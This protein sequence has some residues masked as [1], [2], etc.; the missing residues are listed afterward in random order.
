MPALSALALMLAPVP[1]DTR[2]VSREPVWAGF[3]FARAAELR[4]VIDGEPTIAIFAPLVEE[5]ETLLYSAH[6]QTV[7]LVTGHVF[8]DELRPLKDSGLA[9]PRRARVRAPGIDHVALGE[10]D[11]WPRGVV[12]VVSG[13]DGTTSHLLTGER[14]DA[15]FGHACANIGDIDRD[16]LDD[17]VVGAPGTDWCPN[18]SDPEGAVYVFSGRTLAPL[19]RRA[20]DGPGS[21]FGFALAALDDVDRDGVRDLAVSA[22]FR[23]RVHVLSGRDGTLVRTITSEAGRFGVC[24]V[25]TPDI[26]GDG[27]GDLFVGAALNDTQ[28]SDTGEAFLVSVA[29]GAR[30]RRFVWQW[31]R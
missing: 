17:F 19:W 20:L 18:R 22:Y 13:T 29:T 2:D 24:L 11:V 8:A 7:G 25:A 3:G 16:G 4:G 1:G 12:R 31:P 9:D 30:I 6:V 21:G 23:Q 10:P 5:P 15:F 26:D 28:P 27:I 14:A